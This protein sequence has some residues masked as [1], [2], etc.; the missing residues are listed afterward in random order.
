[1]KPKENR[2]DNNGSAAGSE[3]DSLEDVPFFGEDPFEASHNENKK[4]REA[5]EQAI[6]SAR[7]D[8]KYLRSQLAEA[9]RQLDRKKHERIQ[10][11]RAQ[12]IVEREF[13]ARLISVEKL[14]EMITLGEDGIDKRSIEYDDAVIPV[15]DLKGVPFSLLSTT[16]DY[17]SVWSSDS[18]AIGAKTYRR[19][20]EDPSLW[21]E[22]RDEAEKEEG[23]LTEQSDTR[24]DTISASFTDSG[25][26]IGSNV[27]GRLIYGFDS[28]NADSIIRVYYADGVTSNTIGKTDTKVSE[29]Q[30]GIVSRLN[31]PGYNEIHLRRYD[32]RGEPKKPSFIVVFNNDISEESKKHA[33]FWKIPIINI[34][35]SVYM[36][37]LKKEGDEIIESL[38]E[39][40]DYLT[41]YKKIKSLRS[42]APFKYKL[43]PIMEIGSARASH[44]IAR[45]SSDLIRYYPDFENLKGIRELECRKCIS[46]VKEALEEETQKINDMTM[47]GEVVSEPEEMPRFKSIDIVLRAGGS[48]DKERKSGIGNNKSITISPHGIIEV[49][50][51]MKGEDEERA[52]DIH[53]GE[54][55]SYTSDGKEYKGDSTYYDEL[56]PVVRRYFEAYRKNQELLKA[57]EAA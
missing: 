55:S 45:E 36:E 23:F 28:V 35:Q 11:Q 8:K 34:D 24:G 48:V 21:A 2:E 40:D 7:S 25:T 49:R 16:I 6:A 51:I 39:G 14:D 27:D 9:R 12:E 4:T 13:N 5:H 33:A 32:E 57:K 10:N 54:N 26:N 22:R 52:L 50:F 29:D 44:D 3:W 19:V 15:Y 46:F 38:D 18:G 41:I 31:G 20:M 17:K 43:D 56:G 37:K 30:I 47:R 42:M 1:M 53:D